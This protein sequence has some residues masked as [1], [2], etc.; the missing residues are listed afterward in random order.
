[1]AKKRGFIEELFARKVPQTGVLYVVASGVLIELADVVLPTLGF[2]NTGL[3]FLI[4]CAVVGF[5]FALI[6]S[7]FYDVN[8]EEESDGLP[9][10]VKALLISDEVTQVQWDVQCIN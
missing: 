5:P 4:Y 1:M 6:L 8:N 10:K 7:W 3:R 9:S 2:S